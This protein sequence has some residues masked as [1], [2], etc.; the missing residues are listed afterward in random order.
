[1]LLQSQSKRVALL[2]EL[3]GLFILLMVFYHGCYNLAEI[4]RLDLPFFYSKPM[5]FLQLVIAGDF[6]FIS[7]CVSRYSR[8]NLKRGLQIFSC[9]MV[10]TIVT[11]FVIPSQII[12]FGVLHLLG[13]SMVFFALT[14]KW[15]D[16][17]HPAFGM[18]LCMLLFLSTYF[19]SSGWIGFPPFAA[20]L[21]AQWYSVKFLFWLGIPG[22]G[23]FS[24]DYFSIFPWLF[25]FLAGTFCGVF[26]KENKLPDWV[27]RPHVP[28]LS[29]VGRHTLIIYLLHQ[30]VL[31]GSMML[32]SYVGGFS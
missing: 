15:L 32:I 20:P 5:Q 19:I 6:I 29:R 28:W 8:S 30:P 1:M 16:R 2:D 22:P 7:G 26:F 13:F 4:F 14:R 21:P 18:F 23:F 25:F 10:L 17:I 31:Y 9:G 27:Y 12:L 3:R 11:A 24:S